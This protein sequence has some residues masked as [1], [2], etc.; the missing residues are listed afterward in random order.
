MIRTRDFVVFMLLLMALFAGGGAVTVFELGTRSAQVGA[1]AVAVDPQAVPI[2]E[3]EAVVV[4]APE[5]DRPGLL[6]AM[7]EKVAARIGEFGEVVPTESEPPVV[8]GE[9]APEPA[10]AAPLQLCATYSQVGWA[11]ML[12]MQFREAEGA[13]VLYRTVP[14]PVEMDSATG[15]S[16]EP[17]V[18]EQILAQLPLRSQPLPSPTCIPQDVIGVALDGSLVRN[19]EVGLYRV[20]D[21]DTLIGY[22]LDGFPLYGVSA[23]PTDDCGGTMVGGTYR[24]YLSAQR[25]TILQCFAGVPV[26]L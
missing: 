16:S 22:T 19:N 8:A 12:G 13:R 18:V 4:E 3:K 15:T 24:Y 1:V 14:A 5:I 26:G 2:V 23:L 20:F 7:R 6:A 9:D 21:A 11:D 17:A 25:D 10:S